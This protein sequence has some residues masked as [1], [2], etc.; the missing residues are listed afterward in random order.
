MLVVA[1]MAVVLVG[2][3][4]APFSWPATA[5]VLVPAGV[6]LVLVIRR[7]PRRVSPTAGLRRGVAVWSVLLVAV[8][9]WEAWAFARQP[10]HAHP[11][12]KSPTLSTLLDPI[13]E[14]GPG[15]IVGWLVWLGVGWW[16]VRR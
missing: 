1:G 12:D 8:L 16:L 5:L 13:L 15:R 14:Q 10:I 2:P 6:V 9:A 3:A 7:S 11:S 4:V